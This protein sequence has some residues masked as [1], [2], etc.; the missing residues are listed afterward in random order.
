LLITFAAKASSLFAFEA[1]TNGVSL[2]RNYS[3]LWQLWSWVWAF[4]K[5]KII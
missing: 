2:A 1:M 4:L 3:C 5:I